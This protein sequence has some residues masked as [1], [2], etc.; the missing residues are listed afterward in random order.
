MIHPI[1]KWNNCNPLLREG[2]IMATLPPPDTAT[3]RGRVIWVLDQLF[4]GNQREMS[5]AVGVSQASISRVI[6][7]TQEPGRQLIVA[8][9]SLPTVND[10]WIYTGR[11]EPLSLKPYDQSSRHGD[12]ALPVALKIIPGAPKDHLLYLTG[13]N[14]PIPQQFHGAS[15]YWLRFSETIPITLAAGAKLVSG[16]LLLL[17]SDAATWKGK[18][19]VL[20]SRLCA[21]PIARESDSKLALLRWSLDAEFEGQRLVYDEEPPILAG[22]APALHLAEGPAF[23]FVDEEDGLPQEST[24]TISQRTPTVVGMSA[25]VAVVILMV[26]PPDSFMQ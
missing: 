26:R 4:S 16:D 9:A 19:D 22:R 24:R 6:S 2:T 14:F 11:G 23:D 15:R 17:D 1:R 20:R 10:T 8:I 25:I 3:T 21:V 18:P 5:R 7:G 13:S 12:C